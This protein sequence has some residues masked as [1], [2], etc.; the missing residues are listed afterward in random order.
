MN[1]LLVGGTG[2]I[3][4][5]V[6]EV[7]LEHGHRVFLLNRGQRPNPLSGRTE[8][9]VADINDRSAVRQALGNRGFDVV[10]NFIAYGPND[11]A[12][13]VELFTGRTAQY[14]LISSASAY[15]KPPSHYLITE[16]TPLRNPFWQYS[17]D[18]I[19]MEEAALHAWRE[20]DFPV[21]IVRPGY[22]YAPFQVPGLFKLNF[23]NFVRIRAGKPLVVHSDGQSLW[24]MTFNADF[25][26]GLFG[27]FGN[28]SA[29]G[30]AFHIT[31]DEVLTWDQIFETMGRVVGVQPKLEHVPVEFVK[32]GCP[33]YYDSLRGD[34][35]FSQVLDN[36]KIKI[37]VPGFRATVSFE[38]GMR[39]CLAWLDAHPAAADA[40]AQASATVDRMVELWENVKK[41]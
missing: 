2:T 17:R 9:I 27:L 28:R 19:A 36:T 8:S 31:T 23:Q 32:I 4:T 25:A 22:T 41:Y 38:E 40:T 20:R 33:S 5:A 37:F 3:S 21:T 26:Q 7:C 1:I 24:Q 6:A 12:A 34:K 16:S 15:Q 13:D 35:M 14:I 18:K 11:L 39:R 30:E 29:I 10:A